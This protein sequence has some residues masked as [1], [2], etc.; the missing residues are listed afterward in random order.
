MLVKFNPI[1][2]LV[3]D[4]R[5]FDDFFNTDFS[6]VERG[7][8]PEID[9]KENEKEFVIQAELAGLDK[10][11]FSVKV[12]N[13]MLTISGEKKQENEA[14]DDSFYRVE[15]RYGAFKRSFRLTDSVAA[16]KIKADYRNG[17]LTVTIPKVEKAKPKEIAVDVK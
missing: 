12:E 14:K 4:D 8:D 15:R 9:V 13:N 2:S 17:I 3:R 5:F 11:D 7:F 10:K 1:R 6:P 16:E